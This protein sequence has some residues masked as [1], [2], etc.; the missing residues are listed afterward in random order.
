MSTVIQ[1]ENL[2]KHRY[3]LGVIIGNAL[4]NYAGVKPDLLPSRTSRRTRW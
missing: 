4:L 1:I 3:R 2:S